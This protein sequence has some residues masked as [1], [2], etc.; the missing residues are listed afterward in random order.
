MGVAQKAALYR[1]FA[2]NVRVDHAKSNLT[3]GL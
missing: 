3:A 1:E 2:T